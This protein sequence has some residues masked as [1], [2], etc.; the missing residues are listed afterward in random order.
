MF[1]NYSSQTNFIHGQRT[2]TAVLLVQ[3]GTP[4]DAT[5]KAVRRY[6]KEFLSDRRVVE[7]PRLL[8]SIILNGI[9]LNTRPKQS[10]KKYASIWTKDGSPLK[11]Y[12]EA[13]ASNLRIE[14]KNRGYEDVIVDHAMRYGNPSIHSKL[15]LLRE[16]GVTKLL[17]LPLYPH[18]SGA[19]TAT[20]FDAVAREFSTWRN[21]PEF[22]FVRN[23]HDHS[24]YITALS[25]NITRYWDKH[26]RGE[27]LIMSF[28]GVPKRNLMLGDPYH[29]ECYKTARLVAENLGLSKDEYMVTFQSR[30]GRAEWL[31][32]YT[33]PTLIKLA[34]EGVKKLDIVCPG[35]VSDCLE[36]LEEVKMEIRDAF[37]TNGG[38]EFNYI[39]CLN[40]STELGMVLADV[41]EDNIAGWQ[42]HHDP[43]T[44][45]LAIEL[46]AKY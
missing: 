26:G 38:Q 18:Y 46:G 27:K 39:P 2:K 10:A 37:I 5:P 13:Q 28:H 23:F 7:I 4:D 6:L 36:T 31:Q 33:E 25:N 22:R 24:M 45:K 14:L 1:N 17:L 41:V 21:L 11:I 19:T 15:N 16:Q 32:P 34:K 8:W 35:F 12:T 29:C 43:K 30:F 44:N 42:H 40:D 20:T 3:L 9:I